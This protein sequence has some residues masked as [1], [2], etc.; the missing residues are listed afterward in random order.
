MCSLWCTT[1]DV[2]LDF[3]SHLSLPQG[4]EEMWEGE[5]RKKENNIMNVRAHMSSAEGDFSTML[6]CCFFICDCANLVFGSLFSVSEK[7]KTIY[8]YNS[9]CLGS[10]ACFGGV[11]HYFCRRGEAA[12]AERKFSVESF[13][14]GL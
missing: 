1:P 6:R 12:N 9:A 4:F 7:K 11:F 5:K 14:S 3:Q 10:I 8:G 13:L 2:S